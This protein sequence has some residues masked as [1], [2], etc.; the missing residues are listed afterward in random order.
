[1]QNTFGVACVFNKNIPF[2]F[3]LVILSKIGNSLQKV[4][5]GAKQAKKKY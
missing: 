4:Q 5:F 2:F 3:I 1:M